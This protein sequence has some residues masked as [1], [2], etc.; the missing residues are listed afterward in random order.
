M[1]RGLPVAARNNFVENLNEKVEASM[2]NGPPISTPG[3]NWALVC[4]LGPEGTAQKNV[5][6]VFNILGAFE[7]ESECD[8]HARRLHALGYEWFDIHKVPLYKFLPLPLCTKQEQVVYFD[9]QM[10]SI[11]DGYR[12]QEV[13]A[14]RAL[15][16]RIAHD[17]EEEKRIIA[18][19]QAEREAELKA[20]SQAEQKE[21][22]EQA[23]PE[24]T[25]ATEDEK[26]A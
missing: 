19:R 16:D 12:N 1:S 22:L 26:H 4:V 25:A 13:M 15:Q 11:M 7:T 5:K 2:C 10:K 21:A 23:V 18:E 24:Q 6:F 17:R 3:Q 9:E 14:Q 8:S 20:G